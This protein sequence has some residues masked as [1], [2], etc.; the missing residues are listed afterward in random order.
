MRNEDKNLREVHP[1]LA[2]LT[3]TNDCIVA[4]TDGTMRSSFCALLFLITKGSIKVAYSLNCGRRAISMSLHESCLV[5]T[6][7]ATLVR[8][9]CCLALLARS[10]VAATRWPKLPRLW[11]MTL[12]ACYRG[13][14]AAG[15]S[16][17]AVAVVPVHGSA[18]QPY[19]YANSL[20]P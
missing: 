3:T 10:M 5:N 15:S 8:A 12:R 1:L 14:S 18:V 19:T 20:I 7:G 4:Q 2:S 9:L 6:I 16:H 17:L 13:N 11:L